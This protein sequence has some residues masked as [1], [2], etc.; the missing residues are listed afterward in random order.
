LQLTRQKIR[1]IT[2]MAIL[3][4]LI[5]VCAWISVPMPHGV[6]VTMQTFAVFLVAALLS[7]LQSAIVIAGYILLGVIGVP[8][9]SSGGAGVGHLLGVTGGYLTG[10]LFAAPLAAFLR[11]LFGNSPVGTIIA[12]NIGLLVCYAFGGLWFWWAKEGA[13][14]FAQVV[15][16][17][18][19][20]YIIPDIIKITL[21]VGIAKVIE[22]R[23]KFI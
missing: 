7:P 14:S 15:T 12:M 2:K 4:A 9:F 5:A 22:K 6:A 20:P 10:F 21:A 8:V 17:T 23:I 16:L 1:I 19:L 13:I 18:M 3:I 11:K